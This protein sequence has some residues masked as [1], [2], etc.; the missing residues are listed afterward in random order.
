[1]FSKFKFYMFKILVTRTIMGELQLTQISMNFR[2]FCWI[3]KV[4][5][6]GAKLCVFLYYFNLKRN[7]DGLKSKSPCILLNKK[8]K[9]N[10]TETESKVKNLTHKFR[11]TNLALQF[12]YESQIN[13]KTVM[14]WSS[15][16]KKESSFC[17][18]YFVKR[19]FFNICV[20]S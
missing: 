2:T 17:T 19:T 1:M 20:S 13:S 12:I 14:S 5:V 18:V 15:W 16:K 11:E 6:L 10:K 4:R 9:F 7:Y 3:L 8:I